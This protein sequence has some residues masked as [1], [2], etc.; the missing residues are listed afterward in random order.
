MYDFG[1]FVAES[2]AMRLTLTALFLAAFVA[3]TAAQQ[4][5]AGAMTPQIDA[6]LKNIRAADKGLLAVSEE[7]GRFLRV[8][9]AMRNAV[10]L[11]AL[12]LTLARLA[13]PVRSRR[14][15]SAATP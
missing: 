12:G 1:L 4:P 13:G 3:T 8:L 5:S 9:V 7:D 10:L 6:I 11:A 2:F 15:A 14:L